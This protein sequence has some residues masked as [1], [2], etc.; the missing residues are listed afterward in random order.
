MYLWPLCMQLLAATSLSLPGVCYRA[1]CLIY[2]WWWHS[3]PYLC[4]IFWK[5]HSGSQSFGPLPIWWSS[6]PTYS[7][8]GGPSTPRVALCVIKCNRCTPFTLSLPLALSHST[9]TQFSFSIPLSWDSFVLES[10]LTLG[11]FLVLIYTGEG[12]HFSTYFFIQ[13]TFKLKYETE[14]LHP[15]CFLA[16]KSVLKRFNHL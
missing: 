10:C 1:T 8:D 16:L 2:Y 14:Q 6:D 13:D 3:L 7:C 5:E 4:H 11:Q 9:E 15:W 12:S